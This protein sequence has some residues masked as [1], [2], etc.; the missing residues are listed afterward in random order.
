MARWF[1]CKKLK[2]Q[3]LRGSGI[4]DQLYNAMVVVSEV[5]SR[6]QAGWNGWGSVRSDLRQ[7]AFCMC[8]RESL[9]DGS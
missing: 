3:R 9:K 6:M 1:Y 7:K 4:W 5:K 8:E 2:F